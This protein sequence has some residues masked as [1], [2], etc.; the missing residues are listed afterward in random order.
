MHLLLILNVH[1]K[2]IVRKIIVM[3]LALD[4]D[5]LPIHFDLD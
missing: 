5:T 2:M 1:K 3:K 4:A